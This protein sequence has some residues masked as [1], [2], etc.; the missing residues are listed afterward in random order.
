MLW[1]LVFA[2][3]FPDFKLHA[4]PQKKQGL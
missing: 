2:P 3:V 4:S 1:A